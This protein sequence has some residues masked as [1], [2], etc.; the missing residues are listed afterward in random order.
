[1]QKGRHFVSALLLLLLL[2]NFH[3]HLISCWELNFILLPLNSFS[4]NEQHFTNGHLPLDSF[5]LLN[6][7]VWWKQILHNLLLVEFLISLLCFQILLYYHTLWNFK[8]TSLVD[9][10]SPSPTFFL[11]YK[12]C[13]LSFVLFCSLKVNG[14]WACRN[15]G[16]WPLAESYIMYR[17]PELKKF[18]GYFIND[19]LY[20]N[21]SNV[22]VDIFK[23]N[24][25]L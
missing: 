8:W 1:M 9:I 3:F 11:L 15:F 20:M 19:I 23:W 6:F 14:M 16:D 13:H 5:F 24:S 12:V 7:Q 22:K 2:F 18:T 10:F 17:A 4:L 21:S 25:N